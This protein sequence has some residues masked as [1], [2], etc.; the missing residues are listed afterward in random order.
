MN[1]PGDVLKSV[2]EFM[3]S[4]IILSGAELDLFTL[5]GKGFDTAK[6]LA[7]KT[8]SDLRG[9][10]RLLDANVACKMLKKNGDCYSL[11]QEGKFL[12]ADHPETVLPMVMHM[13]E[14]WNSWS[15][16]TKIAVKG[17]NPHKKS[18]SKQG[19]NSMRAF[20][21]AMHV[22]GRQLSRQI[23]A[24][25]DLSSYKKLLDIGGA[26]GT[27]TMAFLEK[28]PDMQA[29]IFDLPKV[30]SLARKRISEVG[31]K[32][33]VGFHEGDFYHDPLPEG[34]DLA[35]LSAII[36]QNSP[37]Q[38]LDLYKKIFKALV[39]GGSLLIRDHIMEEDR[40]HPLEG[41]IFAINMLAA[42]EGGDT[43]T[44]KEIQSSLKEAG[45]KNAQLIR[46]GEKMDGL[47]KAEKPA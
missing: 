46:Q 43:Y 25:L 26:S 8:G 27:Y 45:F 9:I 1:Q 3:K 2:Q 44:F 31:I 23:A 6:I 42:T 30:I 36:H 37:A 16:L 35:L 32:D 47:V 41:A 33:R 40:V 29:I 4:R 14:I 12:S 22:A 11:S 39:P 18:P 17:Q 24:E 21:G 15:D 5:I 34:C 38:N 10:T 19:E 20:I 7:E 13:N 28:N